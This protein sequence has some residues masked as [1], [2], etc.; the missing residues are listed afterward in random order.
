MTFAELADGLASI[1]HGLTDV[2]ARRV[3]NCTGTLYFIGN[4]GSAAIASHMAAD[5][6]KN[7]K[8]RAMCFN[9]PALVTCLAND[10]G[11]GSGFSF[12]IKQFGRPEDMLFAISSSGRSINIINA[13][14][15]AEA[16]G[17]TIITLSGFDADNLLQRMGNVNFYIPSHKY[18][19]V[20]TCH[21]AICHMILDAVIEGQNG[22]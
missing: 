7:A 14:H 13:V 15:A 22:A 20:E 19:V 12:P 8:R 16:I 21:L 10:L 2:V 6:T 4:G 5:Y 17:M 3:Q 1:P 9:D 11:Y 18:G